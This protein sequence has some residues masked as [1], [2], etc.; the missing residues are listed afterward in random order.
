VTFTRGVFDPANATLRSVLASDDGLERRLVAFVDS[1][2][3]AA[4]PGIVEQIRSYAAAH[5]A[6]PAVCLVESVAGGEQAKRSMS[7]VDRVVQAV[8]EH[9]ID[10]QSFV[11][12]IGVGLSQ[13]R[14]SMGYRPS[15]TMAGRLYAFLFVW[16]FVVLLRV[17]SDGTRDHSFEQRLQF[18]LSLFGLPTGIPL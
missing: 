10:R 4:H 7:V 13:V 16:S 5:P 2:V 9:R 3:L 11:L 12:A 18:L 6:M 17:F 15:A 14:A 1:N 8:D